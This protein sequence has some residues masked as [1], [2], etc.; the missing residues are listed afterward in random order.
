M[1]PG[2]NELKVYKPQ[3]FWNQKIILKTKLR[4]FMDTVLC[5]P[6]RWAGSPYHEDRQTLVSP[7]GH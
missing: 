3:Y 4:P 6:V 7:S 5:L 2:E 1:I